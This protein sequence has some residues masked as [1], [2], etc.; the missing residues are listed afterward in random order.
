VVTFLLNPLAFDHTPLPLDTAY[1]VKV[2]KRVDKK[3]SNSLNLTITSEPAFVNP[4]GPALAAP[5]DQPKITDF[6]STTFCLNKQSVVAISGA[7]FGSA[8]NGSVTVTVPFLDANNNVFFQQFALPVL[9]W[10]ENAIDV[11]LQVPAGA[12][13]GGYTVTVRRSNGKTASGVIAVLNCTP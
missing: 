11:L 7:G 3:T 13:Q 6:Q 5:S 12:L 4:P 2:V 9:L 10:S 1:P 8:A